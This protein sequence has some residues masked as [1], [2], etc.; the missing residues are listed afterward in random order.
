MCFRFVTEK[1]YVQFIHRFQMQKCISVLYFVV[2]YW[3]GTGVRLRTRTP[4]RGIPRNVKWEGN[5]GDLVVLSLL[6]LVVD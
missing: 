3:S 4:P 5:Y 2:L 1:N 6:V